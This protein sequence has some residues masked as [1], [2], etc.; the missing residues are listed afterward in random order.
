M[1]TQFHKF[2]ELFEKNVDYIFETFFRLEIFFFPFYVIVAKKCTYS[3]HA[4]NIIEACDN[5][6]RKN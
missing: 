2:A 4:E 6:E 1:R 5:I 3:C